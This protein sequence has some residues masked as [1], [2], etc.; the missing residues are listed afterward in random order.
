MGH[1]IRFVLLGLAL[2]LAMAVAV[3]R[4]LSTMLFGL[5]PVDIATFGQVVLVVAC[6]SALACAVP[7]T[8]VARLVVTV[9]K[10]E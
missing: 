2:G 1:G 8:R 7:T 3:T 5:A 4:L 9:L 6:V 10:A